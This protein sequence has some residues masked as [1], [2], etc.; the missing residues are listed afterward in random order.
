MSCPF[1][2]GDP[3]ARIP[4]GFVR[5]DKQNPIIKLFIDKSINISSKTAMPFLRKI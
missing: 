3:G 2:R 5:F 1:S 4:E